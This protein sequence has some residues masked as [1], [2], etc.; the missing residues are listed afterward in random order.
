MGKNKDMK[1]AVNWITGELFAVLNNRKLE[2][3]ESPVSAKNLA[4]LNQL[5]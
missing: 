1:L 3:S 5:N 2:I 4:K